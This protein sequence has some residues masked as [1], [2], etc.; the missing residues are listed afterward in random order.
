[1]DITALLLNAV[2]PDYAVRKLAEDS[3]TQF[4]E[5]NFPTFLLSLALELANEEKPAEARRCDGGSGAMR[6]IAGPTGGAGRGVERPLPS[7]PLPF[8]TGDRDRRIAAAFWPPWT[9]RGRALCE[10]VM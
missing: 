6:D 10:A 9:A 7:L 2:K 8:S 4:Q 3:L 5:Q 1:M